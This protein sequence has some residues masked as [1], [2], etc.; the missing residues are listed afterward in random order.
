[1]TTS[2][3]LLIMAKVPTPGASKTRLIPAVGPE[4]AAE[5]SNCFLQD[6]IELGRSAAEQ[7]AGLAVSVAGSPP[8]QE[9]FFRALAP[10][11]GH[12][13]QHGDDLSQRLDYVLA[14]RIMAGHH[15]VVSMNSDS[16]NLP[17]SYLV[18]AFERLDD[19]SVD[20]VFGPADDG[21]YYLIGCSEHHPALV[22]DVTM[23]T[24]TVLADSLVVAD[25]LGLR[26]ALL[27]SWY[28]VDEPADFERLRSDVAQGVPCG[29]H[30]LQFLDTHL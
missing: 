5:L 21:G 9:D 2:R 16:P 26:V 14:D 13:D 11:L 18:D 8:G 27:D 1:M 7:I 20:V 24:P 12:V 25:R 15:Q 10:D 28:D 19:P 17:V 30:T 23:S 22:R 4:R 29:R 6:A 3:S